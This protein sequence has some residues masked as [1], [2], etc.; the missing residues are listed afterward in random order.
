MFHALDT[1]LLGATMRI[2]FIRYGD[3]TPSSCKSLMG[4]YYFNLPT[5]LSL[6]KILAQQ[7]VSMTT[8]F[9]FAVE[10]RRLLAVS[11]EKEHEVIALTLVSTK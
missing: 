5:L 3:L 2:K 10:S 7:T 4:V 8:Q 1:Q 11:A 9:F 6:S